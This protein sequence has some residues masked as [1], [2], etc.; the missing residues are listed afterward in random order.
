VQSER[1]VE[2][3]GGGKGDI[4]IYGQESNPTTWRLAKMN[5][6]IRGLEGDLGPHNADTFHADQ[7]KDLKADFILANPPFNVSDWGGDRL[8]DDVRWKYGAPPP[9]NANFAWVQHM[10]HHLAPQGVAGF[11]LAN[12]SMSSPHGGEAEIRQAIVQADLVDCM[13]A[14][15]G[16]LFYTTQIPVCLWFL[17]RDKSNGP[18]GG[19]PCRD[20]RGETLFIDARQL[21][22]MVDRTHRELTDEDIARIAGAYHAWRR[23][24]GAGDYEDVP[25][26]CKSAATEQ[27]AEHGFVLT[28]GRYVGAAASN[29]D[30]EPFDDQME[31]LTAELAEQF[32]EGR[33]LEEEI[34]ANLSGLGFNG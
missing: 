3:H 7:H 21:G 27:I 34:R 32:A 20:R 31:R 5:L 25:G 28:P 16:Q 12:G 8:R 1:F 33:R 13:I 9:G 24:Q 29:E 30:D 26:F 15:P 10:V 11:V 14:L 17:A 19:G 23:E 2:E 4:G 18:G 6:A 22:A